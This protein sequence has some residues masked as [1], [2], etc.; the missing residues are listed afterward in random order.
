MAIRNGKTAGAKAWCKCPQCARNTKHTVLASVAEVGDI[1]GPD[2]SYRHEHDIVQCDGCETICFRKESMNSED[3]DWDDN[4]IVTVESYPEPKPE[5][6][7]GAAY[8][9]DEVY[10]MP[11]IV[12][13]IYSE[14]LTAIR[15]DLPIL[16]GIGIRAIVEATCHDQQAAGHTLEKKIDDLVH[17]SLLTQKGAEIL[18]GLRLIGNDAAHQIKPPTKEQV[19]AAM[20]VIDH[21][22]IGAYVIP[23]EAKVLPVPQKKTSST[24]GATAGSVPP[25]SPPQTSLVQNVNPPAGTGAGT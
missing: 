7:S 23:N 4:A 6:R 24:A 12:Q 21:L 15:Q 13:S 25:P 19:A 16:A 9:T 3:R 18:H 5:E 1:D 11:G 20:K 14:T 17:Q 8:I 22:L 10:S 2:I